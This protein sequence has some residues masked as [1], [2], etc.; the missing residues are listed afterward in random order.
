MSHF[1]QQQESD[2]FLLWNQD[3][4]MKLYSGN[5]VGSGRKVL[6]AKHILLSKTKLYNLTMLHC[7]WRCTSD[8]FKQGSHALRTET[9]LKFRQ[10]SKPQYCW[11]TC[12]NQ[13][14][15]NSDSRSLEP[16]PHLKAKINNYKVS[17]QLWGAFWKWPKLTLWLLGCEMKQLSSYR[18]RN[19]HS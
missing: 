1:Q 16:P 6:G 15:W 11:L 12:S 18:T 5:Q 7:I 8:L 9:W 4:S 17:D 13:F 14:K 19:I 3:L 2:V 10:K